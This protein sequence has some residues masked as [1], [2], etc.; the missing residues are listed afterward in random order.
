MRRLSFACLTLLAVTGT[1]HRA[2]AQALGPQRQFLAIEPYYERTRL[3]VGAGSDKQ[4]YNGYGARLWI[5]TDPFH[6][7]PDGSIALFLSYTPT[8]DV[9]GGGVTASSGTT[10]LAYGLEYDQYLMRRPLGGLIDPFLTVG[11][12]RYRVKDSQLGATRSYN[13]VPIGGGIRIPIPNRLELR[14]D[15]KDL[16]L[17]DTPTGTYGS[18]RTTHNLLLQAG[19]GVTF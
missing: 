6:F 15:A 5:N 19:V 11:Y 10:Q 2:Q 14:G 16:I 1:A 9:S 7:I 12:E 4:T 18:G 8:Q 17:F 3:D 13:G